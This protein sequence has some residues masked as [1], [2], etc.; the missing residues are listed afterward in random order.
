MSVRIAAIFPH[1]PTRE[2]SNDELVSSRTNARRDVVRL[3]CQGRDG[4]RRD[5]PARTRSNA[6]ADGPEA[7]PA[8]ACR[9]GRGQALA[10]VG[11]RSTWRIC[12]AN[13]QSA[14]LFGITLSP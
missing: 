8:S 3:Y 1:R 2:E 7:G 6:E 12:R 5:R 14:K 10:F 4:G 11:G 13:L 9:A